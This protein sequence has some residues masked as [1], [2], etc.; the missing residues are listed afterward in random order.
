MRTCRKLGFGPPQRLQPAEDLKVLGFKSSRFLGAW[1]IRVLDA[2][3]SDS[4]LL[5]S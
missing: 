4:E 1:G 5:I 3:L 2:R